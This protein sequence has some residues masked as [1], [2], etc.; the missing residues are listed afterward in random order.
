MLGALHFSLSDQKEIVISGRRGHPETETLLAEVQRE[1]HPNIVVA[2]VENGCS[3]DTE[4]LIPLA[5]GRTMKNGRA[6]HSVIFQ[7]KMIPIVLLKVVVLKFVINLQK[8]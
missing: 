3:W 8:L 5:S 6:Y 1:F 2:F 7:V 4:K